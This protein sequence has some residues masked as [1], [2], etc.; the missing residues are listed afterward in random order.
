[1]AVDITFD[2]YYK[3]EELTGLLNK[4]TEEYPEFAALSSIGKSHEGRDIWV[5]TLTNSATGKHGDKPA[6]YVDANIH[7]GE[8]T[9]SV[10]A[11]YLIDYL[12]SNYETDQLIKRLLDTYTFYVLPRI[13]PDGAELYLTTPTLLRSSVRPFP[14][15]RQNE[16]PPGLHA[17]DVNGD[18][19]ILLMRLRDDLRGTW[20]SDPEDIRLMIERQ[21]LDRGGPFYHVYSEGVVRGEDGKLAKE[22]KL[23]LTSVANKYGLDMNR[24]FPSGF[25]PLIPGAGV[26]PL[27]EPETHNQAKFV[28]SHKNIAG[29]LLYHT[30][31]GIIFMPHK[32]L[33]EKNFDKRDLFLYEAIGQLGYEATGYPVVNS[34]REDFSGVFDEWCLDHKGL[35]AFTPELWN[36]ESRATG[37]E[38]NDVGRKLSQKE[39][40][41]VEFKLLAWNDL[42]LGGKGFINWQQ[43]DHP[44][45]GPVEIGGWNTKECRQNPPV[46]F[47]RGECHKMT[48][49]ALSYAAAL[50]EACIDE[51]EVT[52]L[53]DDLFSVDVLVSNRGY[54]PTNITQ[55][56]VR[57][58]AVRPDRVR[59]ELGEGMSLVNGT[60][61]RE[62]GFLEGYALAED[63]WGRYKPPTN[64]MARVSWTVRIPEGS[65]R[66]L[67]V[68]LLSERGGTACTTVELD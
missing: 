15:Y 33:L 47:L 29:V 67:T 32:R 65:P 62:I 43:F 49:F 53:A 57:Q 37:K 8:V 20:K 39:K 38:R 44:Q 13:N 24:N 45:L 50:P 6:M 52:T 54:L 46:S 36:A 4:Y 30:T 5:M 12:L 41:D 19:K 27:S 42:E 14:D 59:L 64:Q 63:V 58:Q 68:W 26:Y 11:L 51:V 17:E 60:L 2:R 35:L 23:P 25:T 10:A 48:L 18:G 9:G 7:A 61:Q 55:H 16:D 40:R 66:Q 34:L 3:Y 31:G 28:D 21:P 22:V 56:A 1:M